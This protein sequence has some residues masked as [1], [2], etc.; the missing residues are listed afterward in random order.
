VQYHGLEWYPVCVGQFDK[1]E[2]CGSGGLA[3]ENT[4]HIP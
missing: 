4:N 3:F 2:V 1:T